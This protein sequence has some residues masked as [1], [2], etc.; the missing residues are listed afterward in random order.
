MSLKNQQRQF[1]NGEFLPFD[2]WSKTGTVLL[3][4]STIFSLDFAL[5]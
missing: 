2:K 5:K 4:N 3:E 1:N